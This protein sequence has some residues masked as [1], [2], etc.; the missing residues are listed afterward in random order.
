MNVFV[1]LTISQLPE[2]SQKREWLV[3]LIRQRTIHRAA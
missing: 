2:I 3:Q 1:R